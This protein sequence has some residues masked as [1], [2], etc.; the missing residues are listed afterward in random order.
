MSTVEPRTIT[1]EEIARR[2]DVCE[3]AVYRLLTQGQI[4]ALRLGRKWLV[5][6]TR[7]EQWEASFGGQAVA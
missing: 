4:P 7:Y 1:V 5:S 3:A 2:L 6:R